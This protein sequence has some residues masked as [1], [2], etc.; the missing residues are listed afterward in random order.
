MAY[1]TAASKRLAPAETET[2]TQSVFELDKKKQ[3]TVRKF[4]GV[5]LVDIREF[6]SDK[7]TQEKKPGKKGISLTEDVWRNLLEQKD[8][9]DAALAELDG[10][11]RKI[12]SEKESEQ[13][14]EAESADA[15]ENLSEPKKE[16]A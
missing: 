10:K 12:A 9:I 14:K 3:V 6:Y 2:E 8:E 16:D 5:S 7:D 15:E 11:K 4:N 1:K 13:P